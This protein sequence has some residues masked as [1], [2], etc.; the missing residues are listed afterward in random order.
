MKNI[1][2]KNLKKNKEKPVSEN[3]K[4]EA[5]RIFVSDMGI[6]FRTLDFKSNIN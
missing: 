5:K 4:M 2:K 6:G 1:M 3:K